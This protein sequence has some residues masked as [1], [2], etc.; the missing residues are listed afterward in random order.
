MERIYKLKIWG[1]KRA[2]IRPAPL[3]RTVKVRPQPVL[4]CHNGGKQT[5]KPGSWKQR[6]RQQCYMAAASQAHDMMSR[7]RHT[8]MLSQGPDTEGTPGLPLNHLRPTWPIFSHHF[9]EFL[10]IV[11]F[12]WLYKSCIHIKESIATIIKKLSQILPPLIFYDISFHSI[13]II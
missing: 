13:F 2:C 10:N 5:V 6:P 7:Q 8:V 3:W 4:W 11:H 1:S 12:W 9:N